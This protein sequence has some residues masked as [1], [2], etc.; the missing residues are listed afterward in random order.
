MSDDNATAPGEIDALKWYVWGMVIVSAVGGGFLW[1]NGKRTDTMR[2]QVESARKALPDI[3]EGKHEIRAML[4][5][6]KKNKED[7]ARESPLTWFQLCWKA[8]GIDNAQIQLDQWKDPPDVGPDGKYVEEKIGMKFSSRTPLRRD[9]IGRLIHEIEHRS[10]RLRV[11]TLQVRRSG[12]DDTLGNDEWTG[13]CE[14]AYR[15]PKVPNE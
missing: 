9:Q 12:R 1:W 13:Q 2:A 4:D 11:L 7:E 14:V 3:A 15:Y 10:T 5:V 8:H 6:Y